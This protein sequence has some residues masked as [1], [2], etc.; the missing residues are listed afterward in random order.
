MYTT[1]LRNY[2]VMEMIKIEQIQ[3]CPSA[4]TPG[5][6]SLLQDGETGVDKEIPE[7]IAGLDYN[8]ISTVPE[9]RQSTLDRNTVQHC[10]SILLASTYGG[11][12]FAALLQDGLLC[13]AGHEE[14]QF[15]DAALLRATVLL[16]VGPNLL[17]GQGDQVVDM[18]RRTKVLVYHRALWEGLDIPSDQISAAVVSILR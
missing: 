8:S 14:V 15:L 4:Q 9:R 13:V 11:S 16:H 6:R 7:A 10:C 18:L 1:A 3:G 17:I 2:D 12:I 5:R